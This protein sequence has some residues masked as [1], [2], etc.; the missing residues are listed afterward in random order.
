MGSLFALRKIVVIPCYGSRDYNLTDSW[1]P[2]TKGQLAVLVVLVIA[3]IL[4]YTEITTM[5]VQKFE[6]IPP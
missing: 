1:A 5:P 6:P 2:H 3:Y 4:Y